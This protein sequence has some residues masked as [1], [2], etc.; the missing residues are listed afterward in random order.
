MFSYYKVNEVRFQ[1]TDVGVRKVKADGS[2]IISVPASI[3]HYSF[4][5]VEMKQGASHYNFEIKDYQKEGEYSA[6]W[7]KY[8][9]LEAQIEWVNI[10]DEQLRLAS[11]QK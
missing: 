11:K 4:Q 7:R 1:K 2:V 8:K 10:V 5:E 9:W 6:A 3:S